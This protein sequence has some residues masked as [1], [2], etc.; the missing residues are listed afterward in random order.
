MDDRE[1][2][3]RLADSQDAVLLR[4]AALDSARPLTG[5]ALL[6]EADG[7]PVAAVSLETG[8]VVAD[9]FQH[10]AAAVRALRLRRYQ[11]T[12]QGERWPLRSLLGRARPHAY[13][14]A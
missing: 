10:S 2:V 12:R 5:R 3:I 1:L 4:L 13:G 11:A 14:S 8:H 9:P 6:A 7:V